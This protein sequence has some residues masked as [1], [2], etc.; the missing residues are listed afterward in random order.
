[1][2]KRIDAVGIVGIAFVALGLLLFA[3]GR[4]SPAHSNIW[5]DWLLAFVLVIV[6]G[7]MAI[8]WP[9]IRVA[10]M[11]DSEEEKP[12]ESKTVDLPP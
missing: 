5:R 10:G 4:T 3:V 11:C 7:A 2:L 9:L 6:G 8:A 12:A 1:M